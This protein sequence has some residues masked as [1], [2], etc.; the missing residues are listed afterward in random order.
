MQFANVFKA[1]SIMYGIP[2]VAFLLGSCFSYFLIISLGLN[3]D[4]ALVSFFSGI[5][6]LAVSYGTIK[7]CDKKGAFNSR[8]QPIITGFAE[9]KKVEKGPIQKIMG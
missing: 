3:W 9:I 1:A 2:L 7:Y 8:Y 4:Q 6:L 5:G